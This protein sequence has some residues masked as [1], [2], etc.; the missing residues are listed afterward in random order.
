MAHTRKNE[1][2]L[3]TQTELA[4]VEQARHPTLADLSHSDL[5]ALIQHLRDKRDRAQTIA[6]N[7]RRA[8][9]GKGRAEIAFDR[10]DAG[11]REKASMLTDALTRA[12]K[13]AG[14]RADREARAALVASA[15]RALEM[16]RAA[17][18]PHHPEGGPSANGGMHV[19]ES[20][21]VDAIGSAGEAG[22]VTKFVATAQAI[23]DARGHD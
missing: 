16:K 6:N 13:E 18:G 22:R 20:T 11:N 7:Q 21:R 15:R 4:F 14:R 1:R 9:R 2:N 23:K 8:I 5:H 10:A 17:G 3:L 19:K 12:R